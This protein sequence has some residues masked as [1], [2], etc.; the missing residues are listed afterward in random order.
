[1]SQ[2]ILQYWVS[3]VRVIRLTMLTSSGCLMVLRLLERELFFHRHNPIYLLVVL[4]MFSSFTPKPRQVDKRL[5]VFCCKPYDR[6]GRWSLRSLLL[7]SALIMCHVRMDL[8][9]PLEL[10]MSSIFLA[11]PEQKDSQVNWKRHFQTS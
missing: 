5:V 10:A 11:R 6:H 1:M 4:F 2:T 8:L 9:V 7:N 3:K